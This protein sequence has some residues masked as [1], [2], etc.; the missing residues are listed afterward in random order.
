MA[1]IPAAMSWLMVS[2]FDS[3]FMRIIFKDM[4]ALS[5]MG[6]FFNHWNAFGTWV[7]IGENDSTFDYYLGGA[8]FFCWTLFEEVIQ[9]VLLPQ[10]F[11]WIDS[12]S[13]KS[14]SDT[15]DD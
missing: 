11:N 6:P 3:P 15:R 1:Y 5:T 2:L 10:V 9:I 7:Y 13:I 14:D 8:I 12:A 4:V